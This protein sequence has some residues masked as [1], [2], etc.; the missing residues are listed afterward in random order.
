VENH[1]I[2]WPPTSASLVVNAMMRLFCVYSQLVRTP[3]E[4]RCL[5][6]SFR[7]GIT[8]RGGGEE[9]NTGL[10]I[11]SRVQLARNVG[12]QIALRSVSLGALSAR[13]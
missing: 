2:S 3:Q 7:E 6:T 8:G 9:D 12:Q 5:R 13:V 10:A 11:I 4:E 1:E